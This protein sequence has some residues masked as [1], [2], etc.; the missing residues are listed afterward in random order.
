MTLR[1]HRGG[2]L[3]AGVVTKSCA[4]TNLELESTRTIQKTRGS[5]DSYELDNDQ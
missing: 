5:T 3:G 1:M 4:V 2:G